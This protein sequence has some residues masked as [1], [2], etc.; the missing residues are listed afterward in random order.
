MKAVVLI[1]LISLSASARQ[2][3]QCASGDVHSF[4]GL[5]INLNDKQSTLFITNGVHLPDQD[6][7]EELKKISFIGVEGKYNLYQ[8]QDEKTKE[9][10]RVPTDVVGE[11]SNYF[12]VLF[13]VV[14][15][16]NGSEYR[17]DYSCFSAI[18]ND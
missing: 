17:K 13:S 1:L 4:D 12:K 6:R 8:A 15:L 9:V 10:L 3:I 7:I 5:V 14:K 18:Y 16:P 2:Y 11:Y